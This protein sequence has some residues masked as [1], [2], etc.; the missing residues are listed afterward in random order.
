MAKLIPSLD[1]IWRTV[2]AEAAYTL[3]R[4]QV[5]ERLPGNPVGVAYRQLEDGAI[6]LMARY[7][8][9]PSFN[10]VVGLRAGQEHHVEPLVRWYRDNDIKA[11]FALVPG[12]S[13]AKLGRELARLG[14][15]Q[16][17]FH[18]AVICEPDLPLADASGVAIETVATAAVLEEFLDA[19]AA[20]W[21]IP[22]PQGF[23]AN[24]RGWLGQ[25]GWSLYL[26]RVDGRPAA[27]GILYVHD[28]V[29]YCADAATDP[30]FRGRGLQTAMLRRRIAD[31]KTAGVDF[32]CSGAEFLSTSHRNMERVGLRVLFVRALWSEG[33]GSEGVR[34]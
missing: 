12:L 25:P 33:V 34:P 8:P 7:L 15:Y 28:R 11:Q 32:V 1:L 24:V 10:S 31:A 19:H 29:G 16:S 14:Y 13:D 17:G 18:T 5:L 4:L 27:T 21:K 2:R 20:G 23:K 22:D 30:A 9:V 26:A 3:S 6:A